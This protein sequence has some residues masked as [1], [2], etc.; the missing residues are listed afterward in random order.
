[1]KNHLTQRHKITS[2][3]RKRGDEE[4]PCLRFGLVICVI[5][6]GL[7]RYNPGMKVL[8]V[9]A[10]GLQA[11]ALSC[12]GNAWIESPN[13]DFLAS[14][15]VVFDQ[16]VAD[17]VEA[18]AVRRTWRSGRYHLP[19]LAATKM[20]P[21][22]AADLLGALRER[23]IYTCLIRNVSHPAPAHFEEGWDEVELVAPHP[24]DS[25]DTPL[26]RTLEAARAALKRLR[27]RSDWLLWLELATPLPPW[28][29]PED[30]REP[31]F[32]PAVEEEGEDESD[33]DVGEEAEEEV[34]ILEPIE[35]VPEGEIDPRD[36]TLF[37]RLQSSYAATVSY[38][39]AGIGQLL[40]D[41]GDRAD[42]V[43]LLITSDSGQLLGEHGVVGPVRPFLHEEVVHLPLVVRLPGGA[44]AGRRIAALTQPVDLAPTLADVFEVALP[45]AHGHSLVPL[46]QGDTEKVRDYACAGHRLGEQAEYCLRTLEWAFLMPVAQE[47]MPQTRGP[48][49]YV[50]PD[51]RWEVNNVV[52]HEPELVERLER[53][54]RAF[55]TATCQ[56][57]PLQVPPLGEPAAKKL[58][59]TDE[60]ETS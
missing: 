33:A 30:F 34:E 36:D 26:V 10:R 54:L 14:E 22:A 60:G 49:L 41:L 1:M 59:S 15:G 27:H 35:G 48:Q 12:Y 40:E 29:V 2:P 17:A 45:S 47:E 7:L 58:V 42:D 11:G 25:E 18:D 31:Y 32:T 19:A 24:A 3:K 5:A 20:P 50:K 53:T 57:E 38:F 13:L 51:D 44:E 37:L 55:V 9:V 43:L 28:D 56:S 52:Q 4:P 39:D 8:V 16:H 46:I 6:R 21:P 23:K